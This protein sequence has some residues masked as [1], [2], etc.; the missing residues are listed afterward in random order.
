[1]AGARI[2]VLGGGFGGI[3]VARRLAA[4]LSLHEAEI[5]LID[6]ESHHLYTP[7]LYEIV[8][9]VSPRQVC[10]PMSEALVGTH[11]EFKQATVDRV[12]LR[13][14]TLT[15]TTNEVIQ[16]DHLVLALGSVTNYYG[17]KG[18][19]RYAF[20]F[21]SVRDAWLLRQH[22]DGQ[23]RDAADDRKSVAAPKLNFLI[24]GGGPTGVELAGEIA[25]YAGRLAKHFRVPKSWFR[26]ELV[27]AGPTVA[28]RFASRVSAM[29]RR[30]LQALG[31]RI[32][33][34]T[35]VR[36]ERLRAVVLNQRT[37]QTET[38]IWTAGVMPNPFVGS[39]RGLTLD[40]RGHVLVDGY[41]RAFGTEN[42]WVA[43]D[44]A[45]TVDAG[46]AYATLAQ[47]DVVARNLAR[48]VLGSPAFESYH[49]QS[50]KVIMP[51]GHDYAVMQYG[52]FVAAGWW[53]SLLR[54]LV[55]FRYLL[56]VLP[57]GKALKIWLVRH[58]ACPSCKAQ[59]RDVL[60]ANG[61][62]S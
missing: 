2:V 41:M 8:G 54:Q 1:M 22:I 46:T 40:K 31:V 53:V 48:T 49:V 39:I 28:G 44:I 35:V 33:T 56:S 59:L 15:L 57:L 6:R 51:I 10:I 58:E 30:R 61:Q 32:V 62:I 23:F 14:R 52:D 25:Q 42:V 47:A 20:P 9:G 16:F 18:L 29:V 21:K 43:G 27:E 50:Q 4:Q 11:V 26:V 38:L 7:S 45:A 19:E 12:S 37:E 3:R 24:A 5:T 55:D 34:N 17:I 60:W 36:E 13:N